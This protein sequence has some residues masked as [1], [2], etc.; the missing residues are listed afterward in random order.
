MHVIIKRIKNQ[1]VFRSRV[2]SKVRLDI[3]LVLLLLLLLDFPSHLHSLRHP[4][5]TRHQVKGKT[6]GVFF[7]GVRRQRY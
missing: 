1:N 4:I 3:H 5:C 6:G 7:C 2:E